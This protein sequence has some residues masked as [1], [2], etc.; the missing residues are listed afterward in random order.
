M[1]SFEQKTW[2]RGFQGLTRRDRRPC[3]Y[4]VYLPDPLVGRR[5]ALDGDVAADVAD[6][7]AELVRF[8][9][10][11]S[12][13]ANTE[14]LARL[15]L[16][17]ESVASSKI[18]GLEV[19]GR[20]LLRAA[21]AQSMGEDVRDITAKEVLANID[22]MA[23][24][25]EAVESG[26]SITMEILLEV[27]RRLLAG[28]GMEDHGGLIREDQNW[29]G[30]SDYNP[31][32]AVFVPPPPEEVPSLLQ[33]LLDFCN[34]DSLPAIAQAAI[35]HAQ[36]ETIHPFADGNGRTG[37]ALIQ[38]VLRR[39]GITPRFVPPVSLVLATRVNEYLSGLT[40]TRYDGPPDSDNAREGI[41]QWVMIFAGATRRAVEDALLFEER[42]RDLQ[43]SWTGR[44]GNPRRDSTVHLIVDALPAAPILTIGTAAE[45]TSRTYEATNRAISLLVE[46]NVLVQ[47]N[48]GRRNRAFEAPELIDMF[49]AL[50]RQLASPESDTRISP[51]N[52][53]VP[54]R[55]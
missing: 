14:A 21:A 29:I 24:G 45:L 37:R 30:G 49:T 40:A 36:F 6:A 54:A 2:H 15:L 51:P 26:S 32:S 13:L 52:R 25:I 8:N 41:N 46:A 31:C 23:Q 38:L 48:V 28:S 17:A 4:S 22:A 1:A 16:R 9:T 27:H 53:H 11:A 35:A 3:Q 34:E 50:E 42:V 47:T 20:R 39:R 10:A 43:E 19:G 5:F 18:E 55:R 12:V 33:D 44:V 7:E